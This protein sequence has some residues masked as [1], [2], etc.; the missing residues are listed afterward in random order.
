MKVILKCP[1]C[2]KIINESKEVDFLEEA[3]E[4][5]KDALTNPLIGWCKDCDV[6][7]IPII[8]GEYAD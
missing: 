2:G 3:K 7:P 8:I 5:H 6:K 4:L 1:E